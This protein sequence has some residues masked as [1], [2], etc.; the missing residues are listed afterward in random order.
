MKVVQLQEQ[1]Q[2]QFSNPIPAP[3][4]GYYG[5]TK[6]EMTEILIQNK[7]SEF[8]ETKKIKVVALYQQTPKQFEPDSNPT[9]PQESPISF[10]YSML[11]YLNPNSTQPQLNL[12]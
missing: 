10:R 12:N 9:L 8:K 11:T 5:P 2:K 1:T 7:M 4:T 6:S 3:K